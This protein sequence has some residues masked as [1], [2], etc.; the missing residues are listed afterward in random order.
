MQSM[1][2][3]KR[4]AR[5]VIQCVLLFFS[6]SFFIE[7]CDRVETQQQKSVL[8]FSVHGQEIIFSSIFRAFHLFI[9]ATVDTLKYTVCD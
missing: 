6:L 4:T 9:I 2:S 5:A 8:M 3:C 1:V 7:T